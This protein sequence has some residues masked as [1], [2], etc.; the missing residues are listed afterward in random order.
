M[1]QWLRE[2]GFRTNPHAERLETI[3]EVAE[4]CRAWEAR[5]GRLDYEID[6]IVIK[7]D[8]LDQ[9]RGSALSTG[10]RAG[11]APTSGRRRLP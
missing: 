6:G 7:V 3:E 8:D 5:R 9:Q 10:D 11:R 2:H 1:L 4:A